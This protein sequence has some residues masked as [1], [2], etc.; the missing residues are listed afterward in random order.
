MRKHIQDKRLLNRR[1]FMLGGLQLGIS[2]VLIGRL[3][4]L[5]TVKADTYKTLA[6][7]NRINLQLIIPE[8]GLIKDRFDKPLAENR[9]NYQLMMERSAL[10]NRKTLFKILAPLLED[11]DYPLADVLEKQLRRTP[12][13]QNLMLKEY[14]SWDEVSAVE[15][16]APK[17]PGI[18]IET[19]TLRHYT[20]ES[21]AS[22]LIGY[23]GTPSPEEAKGNRLLKMP[24]IKIG[25]S[26]LEKREEETLQGQAGLRHMEVNAQ[27]QYL[28]EIDRQDSTAGTDI[29]CTIS[30]ELQRY[31][32]E[33]LGEESGAVVA[34]D[35]E[36]GDVLA[37]CSVPS[38]DPNR[39]SKGI[40][41]TY[42]NELMHNKKTPLLN[43]A[44][45]GQYPPGSTYKMLVGLKGLEEGIIKP[46]STFF[47]PGH[48]FLGNH[49]FNCWK[50][51]G[52]G[53]MNF[54]MAIEQSCDTFFYNVAQRLGIEK[55]AE[56]SHEFGLGESFNLGIIGEKSGLIPT[57]DWK[58]ASYNQPWQGGDTINASIGQGY[59]LT[60]PLQLAV[61][62]A[63]LAT[64]R[65]VIPR[66]T[67]EGEVPVFEEVSVAKSHLALSQMAMYDV[68]H[69]SRGTARAS[70][71]R[72]EGYEMAG[73]T[74]T[75]QVRRITIRGQDQST[76]PWEQR[77]HA[78]FVAFAPYQKPRYAIS[79]VI[80]HGG[81]GSSAAAPVAKDVMLKLQEIME[82][83]S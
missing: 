11:T 69:G 79:V 68:T 21:F 8:R 42:W 48:F 65:K 45:T 77:H 57:P 46:H 55:M 56:I 76:I 31:A 29:H 14:L 74:G 4:Q 80:E 73:K 20:L 32:S 23:V 6:E 81:G 75:S 41:H 66:L 83:S 52:H 58:R 24:G 13:D 28:H 43:K 36:T 70:Q 10:K 7:D 51:A 3:W 64:G 61:M 34:L 26:G 53:H 59:V 50:P 47:C 54:R 5:Q 30:A 22:H 25:K 71:I 49:R 1:A 18:F 39:F 38:F 72:K 67:V 63:R 37:L 35:I 9:V 15:F 62:T 2:S 12:H 78:L 27:G 60:T 82:T 17:L 16:N 19:G 44:I 40:S 33:R